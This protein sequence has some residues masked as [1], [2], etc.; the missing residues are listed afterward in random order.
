MKKTI[1]TFLVL[2]I[3]SFSGL[4]ETV[5]AQSPIDFGIKGGLNFSTFNGS[6]VEYEMYSDYNA[7]IAIEISLP[8]LPVGIESGVYYSHK[9][10]QADDGSVRLS[11]EYIEIP[12]L[13]KYNLGLSDKISPHL[14]LGPYA[15]Y[16]INSSA[17]GVTFSNVDSLE[18]FTNE[19][20]F[21][22]MGG[23]GIDLNVAVTTINIQARYSYGFTSVFNDGFDADA[24][25]G[26]I[27][28]VAGIMF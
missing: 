28:L 24:K 3:I 6:D 14:V 26:V 20:D 17:R 15:G 21:G 4:P 11:V 13:A 2:F 18:D 22:L 12:L 19:F 27:S 5:S 7:G 10:A 1:T 8:T 23:A 25:N 9:G 16:V